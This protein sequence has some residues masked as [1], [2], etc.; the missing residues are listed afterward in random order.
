MTTQH[1]TTYG[2]AQQETDPAWGAP[3]TPVAGSPG[4]YGAAEAY[5]HQGSTVDPGGPGTPPKS[6]WSV[7]KTAIV[8]ILAAAVLAVGGI[9]VAQSMSSNG[10]TTGQGGP[11]GLAGGGGPMGGGGI[12]MMR[13]ALHGDFT[14]SDGSGGYATDRLQTGTVTAVTSTSLTVKSDDGYTQTYVLG[15]STTVN[16]TNDKLSDIAANDTVTVVATVSGDTATA[17]AVSEGDLGQQ[18]G[19]PRNNAN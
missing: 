7:L 16:S 11:G 10:T 6:R 19:P 5:R 13:D 3:A 2:Q 12:G 8:A 1:P 9:A 14:V 15:S 4:G 18:G 17:T